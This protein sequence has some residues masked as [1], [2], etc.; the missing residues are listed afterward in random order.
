MLDLVQR[1]NAAI[2]NDNASALQS[3]VLYKHLTRSNDISIHV[4][5][6]GLNNQY[7]ANTQPFADRC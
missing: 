5:M 3:D 7:V 6:S 1:L 2:E 4:I